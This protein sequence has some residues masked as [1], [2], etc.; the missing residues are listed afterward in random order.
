MWTRRTLF[1]VTYDAHRNADLEI[2]AAISL[3]RSLPDIGHL[4][5]LQLHR[6]E[7]SS[8][9][10]IVGTSSRPKI[11]VRGYTSIKLT[12]ISLIRQP[13]ICKRLHSTTL[14]LPRQ[15]RQST[16]SHGGSARMAN[17]PDTL[18]EE[19]WDPRCLGEALLRS[20]RFRTSFRSTQSI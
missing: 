17:I 1:I 10:S 19:L 16:S 12:G 14:F 18:A 3:R 2:S 6:E 5:G 8:A 7:E 4:I 9:L 11:Q 15:P 13:I 20:A